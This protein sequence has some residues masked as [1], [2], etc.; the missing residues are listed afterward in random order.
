MPLRPGALR[1]TDLLH[2]RRLR[3]GAALLLALA[4]GPAASAAPCR[5]AALPDGALRANGVYLPGLLESGDGGPYLELM[6]LIF[7]HGKPAIAAGVE[8]L[9]GARVFSNIAKGSI[10]FAFPMLK[11]R[12]GADDAQPYRLSSEKIGVVAFVIYSRAGQPLTREAIAAAAARGQP[13]AIEAPPADWGFPTAKNFKLSSALKKIELGRLDALIW[14][15]EE[16]DITLRQLNL[17]QIQRGHFGDYDEVFMLPRNARGDQVDCA[18][19]QAIREARKGGRLQAAYARVHQPYSD[20]QTAG[21][22]P[23]AVATRPSRNLPAR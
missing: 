14:A 21:G 16:A 17:T 5:G 13:Y 11:V 9:P 8:V 23:A 7:S 10:D 1:T 15:Q 22:K 3:A 6:R 18:L 12:Q 20:W 4:A 2:T 19:T